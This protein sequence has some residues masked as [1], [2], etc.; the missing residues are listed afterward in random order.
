MQDTIVKAKAN[1]LDSKAKAEH[2]C[3]NLYKKFSKADGPARTC[4]V[5]MHLVVARLVSTIIK[6]IIIFCLLPT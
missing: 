5:A 2:F 3:L 1:V 4:A 6:K